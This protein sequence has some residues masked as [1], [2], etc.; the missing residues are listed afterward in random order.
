L[1]SRTT[2]QGAVSSDGPGRREAARAV[3][4]FIAGLN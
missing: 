1:W 2:K 3:G 4:L